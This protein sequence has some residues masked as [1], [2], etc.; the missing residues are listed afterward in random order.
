MS[1]L[2][3]ARG[4]V[5]LHT[6]VRFPARDG[7]RLSG[8]Y[9]P[10]T[11]RAAV[12]LLHGAGSTRSDVLEHAVVLA[13]HGYGV[14]LSDARG[15]GRSG[16][17]AMDFGWHGDADIAGAVAFLQSRPDVDGARVGVVGMS[18][19]GEEAIG[20]AAANT[21]IRAVVAEGATSRTAADKAF[22]PGVYGIGGR[23]QQRIDATSKKVGAPLAVRRFVR[24]Q[25]GEE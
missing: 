14:L 15:H 9:V 13:R 6:D 2:S 25:M 8:W 17:R 20:A 5:V 11:G 19:G 16:G 12:L 21:G 1:V 23:I 18:M 4:P 22:L 7:V 3:V 10:S 24:F